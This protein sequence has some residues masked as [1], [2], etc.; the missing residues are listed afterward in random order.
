M[1]DPVQCQEC[2][3]ILDEFRHVVSEMS[4]ELRNQYQAD[5]EAFMKMIGGTAEDVERIE[6]AGERF[7]FPFQP[8]VPYERSGSHRLPEGR[9]P[10][11]QNVVRKMVVHRF[12]TGHMILF[13]KLFGR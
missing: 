13:R 4:P 9:Y 3:A 1:N 12:R 5:R 10:E 8:R 2:E 7:R 6:Q 11:I